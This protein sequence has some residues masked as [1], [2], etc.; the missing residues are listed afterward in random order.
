[1][2]G[3]HMMLVMMAMIPLAA[4]NPTAMLTPIVWVS[5]AQTA[6]VV[7]IWLKSKDKKT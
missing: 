1:M 6:V 7:A 2:F 5:F 4:G 3:V